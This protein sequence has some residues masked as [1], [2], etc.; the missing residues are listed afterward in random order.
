MGFLSNML[1]YILKEIDTIRKSE[2]LGKTYEG[3]KAIF[4][5]MQPSKKYSSEEGR[6]QSLSMRTVNKRGDSFI[7]FPKL[8]KKE[9]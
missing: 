1:Q 6:R 8:N 5:L 3:G 4:Q 9:G 7:E 2:G